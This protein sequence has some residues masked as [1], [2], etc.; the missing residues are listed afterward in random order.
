MNPKVI[1]EKGKDLD[2]LRHNALGSQ[3][4]NRKFP[5]VDLEGIFA[6]SS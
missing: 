5:S 3:A 4:E 2:S 6:N 1:W